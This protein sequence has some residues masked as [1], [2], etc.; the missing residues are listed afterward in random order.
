MVQ[1]LQY[2]QILVFHLHVGQTVSAEQLM[3]KQYAHAYL[4]TLAVHQVVDQN[5]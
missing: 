1:L 2:L 3:D 5:V 4:S